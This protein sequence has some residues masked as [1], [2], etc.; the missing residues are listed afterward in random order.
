M[1]APGLATGYPFNFSSYTDT[2]HDPAYGTA[3]GLVG[4]AADTQMRGVVS[5]MG[6]KFSLHFISGMKKGLRDWIRGIF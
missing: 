5:A 6:Q 1:A 2:L 3:I 4:W